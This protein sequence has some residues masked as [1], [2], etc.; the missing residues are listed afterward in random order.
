MKKPFASAAQL[1]RRLY[2]ITSE[3]ERLFPGRRFTLDGHLVGSIGEA[4]AAHRYDLTLMRSSSKGHDAKAAD[5]RRVQVKV[6]QGHRVA[7]YSS[8]EHLLVLRLLPTG[9]VEE[10][11]NGPGAPAWRR[12][13]KRQKNGQRTISFRRLHQVAARL[14]PADRLKRGPQ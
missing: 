2:E 11:Y 3:L 13:G 4:L 8:P 12:A 10:A 7:L 6:T 5:G 14:R 9:A 1:V